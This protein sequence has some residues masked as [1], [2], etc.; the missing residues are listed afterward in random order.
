M[1]FILGDLRAEVIAV[2]A[3][4]GKQ[5]VAQSLLKQM[6]PD[7]SLCLKIGGFRGKKLKIGKDRVIFLL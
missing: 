3:K 7:V 4:K 2:G 1:T 6:H 5:M